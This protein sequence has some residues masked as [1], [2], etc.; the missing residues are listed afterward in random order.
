MG[1]G[2]GK[3]YTPVADIDKSI[4]RGKIDVWV[5]KASLQKDVE[6]FGT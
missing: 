3:T 6:I 1:C 5:K 2:G 4:W